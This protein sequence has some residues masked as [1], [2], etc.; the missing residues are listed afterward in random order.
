[1]PQYREKISAAEH[2]LYQNIPY[3]WNWNVYANFVKT[4]G[5]ERLTIV[6]PDWI[7]KGGSVSE[8]NDRIREYM[9]KD[10]SEKIG[11][12]EEL[13]K[14][15]IPSYPPMARRVIAD[16]GWFDSLQRD[17]V[18]LVTEKI[19]RFTPGGIV[20]ADGKEREFDLVVSATGFSITDYFG[21]T[22]IVGRD[23][24]TPGELWAKDGPRAYLS[25]ML[26]HFPNF[27]MFYGPNGTPT[28]GGLYTWIECWA[29]YCVT[30][31]K[32]VIENGLHS[33]AVTEA[34]Y[35]A[36]NEKNDE[37][38]KLNVRGGGREY[39]GSYYINEFGRA[40]TN[41]PFGG[42]K[43]HDMLYQPDLNDFDLR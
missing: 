4:H 32:H 24:R 30:I 25:L 40:A 2:Y 28:F 22:K 13:V 36:Y 15:L 41:M 5:L 16:S 26:P 31:A 43:Y 39:S 23:G 29:R 8:H 21:D 10:I 27:F 7:A 20:S 38:Q 37:A 12:K 1:M 34:G 42:T 9:T 14:K 6:D 11:S 33:A 18:E 3:Y 19:L 17:N 35:Y